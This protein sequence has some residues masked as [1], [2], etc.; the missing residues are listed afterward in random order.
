MEGF[1]DGTKALL[2]GLNPYC[3]ERYSWRKIKKWKQ[4]TF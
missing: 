2:S 3:N 1:A 4:E